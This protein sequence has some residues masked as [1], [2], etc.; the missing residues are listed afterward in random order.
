MLT[1]IL[2][3]ELFNFVHPFRCPNDKAKDS[4]VCPDVLLLE[5]IDGKGGVMVG[6]HHNDLVTRGTILNKGKKKSL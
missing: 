2:T 6:Q 5:A 1:A 3:R 4:D